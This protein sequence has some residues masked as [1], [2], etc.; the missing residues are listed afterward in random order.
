[1][2]F[3]ASEVTKPVVVTNKRVSEK[4]IG[5]R[6][7]LLTG[8]G[9]PQRFFLRGVFTI[10]RV[11]SGEDAGFRS[12]VWGTGERFFAPMIELTHEEW[13]A[14]FKR[15]QGNFAFGFQVISEDRFIRGLE[16]VV[17]AERSL[18]G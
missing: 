14:D 5:S 8:Q 17:L 7:W 10:C 2:G 15:S 16:S 3:P 1:M 12:R 13:F 11:E 4:A 6:I 18:A 9:Q